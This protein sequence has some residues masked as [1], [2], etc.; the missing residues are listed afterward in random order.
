MFKQKNIVGKKFWMLTIL[1]DLWKDTRHWA[2]TR[3]LAKCDCGNIK[4]T[5]SQYLS[6]SK[7]L[8]CWCK[9]YFKGTHKLSYSRIYTIYT[10]IKQRCNNS[11]AKEYKYYWL[12]WIKNL[13]NSFE[14]FRDD[15]Y[16][17]YL[18][19]V[20]KYWEK[21]TSIDRINNDW[22]YCK[23]NCRW[24]TKK[25]QADNRTS[26]HKVIIDWVTK[27]ICE[28][29]KYYNINRSTVRYRMN[30]KWMT[31]IDALIS[32]KQQWHSKK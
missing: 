23:E 8:C 31:D 14:E 19:H 30:I 21:N 11:I 3:Y 29:C 13:W 9:S 26:N 4:K 28:W 17:S 2:Y 32:K 22:N 10:M 6:K 27:G 7:Y 20:E 12:R 25:E 5:T 18:K 16:N 24:A 1:E 15:M